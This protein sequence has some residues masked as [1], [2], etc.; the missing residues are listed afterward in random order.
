MRKICLSISCLFFLGIIFLQS[1][2]ITTGPRVARSNPTSDKNTEAPLT[3]SEVRRQ[4]EQIQILIRDLDSSVRSMNAQLAAE[5]TASREQLSILKAK[6]EAQDRFLAAMSTSPSQGRGGGFSTGS[7]SI[8]P[9]GADPNSAPQLP[10]PGQA[11]ARDGG[12]DYSTSYQR[13][14]GLAGSGNPALTDPASDNTGDDTANS[15]SSVAPVSADALDPATSP[16]VGES[17]EP[18][19]GVSATA[20]AKRIYDIAYQDLMSENYQLALL[21]FRA[22]L[23]RYPATNLSDNAQYW[24]GEV[25]YAQRQFT[26]SVEQFRK[27]VEEYPGHDKIPAAYYKIALC[28]HEMQDLPTAR[29]YL[30]YLVE[31]FDDSRESELARERLR[32]W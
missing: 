32:E 29:R 10:S 14:P 7:G 21:N 30:N 9:G 3:K 13:D 15:D 23:D 4:L 1:G 2:C 16:P 27:V 25:Y 31:H 17:V 5:L 6:I 24:I 19:A 26:V 11:V 22:F 12:E 18:D 20:D 8:L 28:F